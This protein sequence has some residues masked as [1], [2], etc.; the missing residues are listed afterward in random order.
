MK[1]ESSYKKKK[2]FVYSEA[3]RHWRDEVRKNGACS[4][5]AK[6]LACSHAERFGYTVKGC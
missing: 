1:K 3:Y 5:K 2:P 6:A 4:D